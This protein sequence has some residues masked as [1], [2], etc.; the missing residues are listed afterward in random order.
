MSLQADGGQGTDSMRDKEKQS[1][2]LSPP[3][4]EEDCFCLDVSQEAAGGPFSYLVPKVGSGM[5]KKGP[6]WPGSYKLCMP[7]WPV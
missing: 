6:L 2:P 3:C 4:Q 1:F 5:E 7:A